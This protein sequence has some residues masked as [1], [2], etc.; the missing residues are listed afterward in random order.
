MST[1]GASTGD[2]LAFDGSQW[3]PLT[4]PS[5]PS[6]LDDLS[7][8]S[9][10]GA[11]TGDLLAFDGSQ[12]EPFAL[13]SIP[14]A[15]GDLS[16][17]T[18]SGASTGDLLAFDGS[19]WEPFALPSIPSALGDLSDVDTSGASIGEVLTYSGSQWVPAASVAPT[20]LPASVA[21]GFN[22]DVVS[23]FSLSK[24]LVEP[25][26]DLWAAFQTTVSY[27]GGIYDLVA[28]TAVG[29]HYI[30]TQ[31]AQRRNG[32]TTFLVCAKKG[33]Q[34]WIVLSIAGTN[35]RAWFNLN[36]G[37][38]GSISGAE[39][40][41]HTMD[42][43]GD[44]WYWCRIT[45]NTLWGPDT[46]RIYAAGADGSLDC[47]DNVLPAISVRS[48]AN[49]R[50]G[51]WVH[52]PSVQRVDSIGS[53][54]GVY[55]CQTA[56]VE[57]QPPANIYPFPEMDGPSGGITFNGADGPSGQKRF[58]EILNPRGGGV[59]DL[60]EELSAAGQPWALYAV[61]TTPTIIDVNPRPVFMLEGL[62]GTRY[63]WAGFRNGNWTLV[64]KE[65]EVS[66]VAATLA[67]GYAAR[68]LFAAYY[69]PDSLAVRINTTTASI[70]HYY[71]SAEAFQTAKL[72]GGGGVAFAPQQC[73]ISIYGWY[74]VIG[75]VTVGGTLDTTVISAVK[76]LHGL[77]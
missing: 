39:S 55:V 60:V 43:A 1:S 13:P 47:S 21:I 63:H 31:V 62:T 48:A 64:V 16:D 37:S 5:I 42:P 52:Q 36:L 25:Q 50:P 46:V 17:V 69:S 22:F 30:D 40:I 45:S 71:L 24:P 76:A 9:T 53:C 29:N 66:E 65:N 70:A 4:F 68:Q 20:T 51:A 54:R 77:V 7:D 12:W 18:T 27:S 23:S 34:D 32:F 57:S 41:G 3:E 33:V 8:V 28:T 14:S 56:D 59:F 6:A 38:T 73:G 49:G 67:H 10:S 19:Q 35:A 72:G 2:L 15:L 44:G 58:L 75:D 11:S 61:A 74:L 26:L